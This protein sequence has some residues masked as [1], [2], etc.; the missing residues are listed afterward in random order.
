MD[1]LFTNF[2]LFVLA[3]TLSVFEIQIEG[4]HGWAERLPTWRPS[5]K[6]WY[7]RLYERLL[8]GKELTGYHIIFFVLIV[9]LFHIQY[10]FGVPFTLLNELKTLS[11]M[12][13][14]MTTED[15]LWF[16]LNPYYG[17]SRFFSKQVPWHSKRIFYFPPEYYISLIFSFVVLL[18]IQIYH[19]EDNI[20]YWWAINI[21]AFGVLG[22]MTIIISLLRSVKK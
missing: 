7:A 5:I 2:Y 15:F 14:F 8:A 1:I 13:L 10:A 21:L 12:C 20:L 3:L 16:V 4:E 19:L 18:P 22:L 9:L 11:L 6:L 17:L